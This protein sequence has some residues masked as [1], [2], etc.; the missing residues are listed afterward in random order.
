[1][2]PTGPKGVPGT[3]PYSVASRSSSRLVL[4]RNP[5]F[6]EW[7]AAAQ[8]DGYPDRIVWTLTGTPDEQ[9][10]AVEQGR[11]DLVQQPPVTRYDQL[12]TLHTAQ[13]HVFP[14]AGTFALF[15]NTRIPPFN[16]LAVRRA[17]NYAIDRGKVPAAFGGTEN[18][19]VTCQILPVGTPGFQPRCPYTQ[20]PGTSWS[21]PNLAL[22]RRLVASSGT[23]GARVAVYAP[24]PARPGQLEVAQLGV[25]AL[26][27]LGYRARLKL[28][29]HDV[30]FGTVMDPRTRAQ[31]G[32]IGVFADYPAASDMLSAFTCQAAANGNP[33]A[34]QL[35]DH[36]LDRAIDHAL[37]AQTADL[38]SAKAAWAHIDAQVTAL[39]PWVP[40]A[41][42]RSIVFVSR[43][44][45]DVQVHPE[46]G[47]L[48][49][50]LW[51]R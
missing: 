29:P 36:G 1:M 45:G 31:A 33:S 22:A 20:R 7:S 42:P 51:V 9:T 32:F 17:L 13:L 16:K 6:R 26:D 8:P 4:V 5:Y 27:R 23:H 48:V 18:A 14:T 37:A 49:D 38:P 15:L 2:K 35:C 39:A 12:A 19:S 50:Q 3:G 25:A 34:S 43:R 40:L 47:P 11:A 30:Y 44:V 24:T 10:T 21:A 46:F 28:V 41:T